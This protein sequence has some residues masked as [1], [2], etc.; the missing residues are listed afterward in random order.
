MNRQFDLSLKFMTAS[1][2]NYTWVVR[3]VRSDIA[4]VFRTATQGIIDSG[5]FDA[6]KKGDVTALLAASLIERIKAN[7]S[8]TP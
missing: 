7:I 6:G 2:S 5:A 3:D 1:G 8:L 4:T